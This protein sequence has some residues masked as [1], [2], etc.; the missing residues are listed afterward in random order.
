MRGGRGQGSMW[1]GLTPYNWPSLYPSP[2]DPLPS[3]DS[4]HPMTPEDSCDPDP[5]TTLPTPPNT[6]PPPTNLILKPHNPIPTPGPPRHPGRSPPPSPPTPRQI[7]NTSQWRIQ[8]FPKEGVPTP[9]GHQH[10]ILP[11]FPKKCMKLKEFGPPGGVH[12]PRTP[13]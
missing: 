8:D 4:S 3:L 9:R 6:Q 10:T 5:Y 7:F 13:S 11:N 12:I 1:W 2:P